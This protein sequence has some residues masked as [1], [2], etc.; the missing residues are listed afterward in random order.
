MAAHDFACC[1]GAYEEVEEV[2]FTVGW[3]LEVSV[4]M[5]DLQMPEGTALHGLPSG[6]DST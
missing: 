1:V 5:P 4:H 6:L 2:G 3:T